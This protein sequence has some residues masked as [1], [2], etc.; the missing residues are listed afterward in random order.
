MTELLHNMKE[1][2]IDF[3]Y[4]FVHSVEVSG[5]QN[6]LVTTFFKTSSSIFP[7]VQILYEAGEKKWGT[8]ESK[9]IDILCHRSVPQLRQSAPAGLVSYPSLYILLCNNSEWTVN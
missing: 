2:P 5:N 4:I 6:G 3:H 1:D 7:T 9:F 8:D